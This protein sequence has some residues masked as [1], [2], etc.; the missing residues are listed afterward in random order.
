MRNDSTVANHNGILSTA[1]A[2][3]TAEAHLQRGTDPTMIRDRSDH[4][5]DR[6]APVAPQR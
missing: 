5:R 2:R 6:L 4:T 1:H 3:N